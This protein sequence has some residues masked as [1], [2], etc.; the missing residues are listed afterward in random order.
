MTQKRRSFEGSQALPRTKPPSNIC[1]KVASFARAEALSREGDRKASPGAQG[2]NIRCDTELGGCFTKA[3]RFLHPSP[4]AGLT[5]ALWRRLWAGRGGAA[6]GA[7][8]SEPPADTVGGKGGQEKVEKVPG[9]S[10]ALPGYVPLSLQVH[11][12]SLDKGNLLSFHC[13]VNG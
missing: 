11:Y 6:P 13:H 12:A 5:A 9:F 2:L 7:A 8:R 4:G 1:Y 3:P 10:I